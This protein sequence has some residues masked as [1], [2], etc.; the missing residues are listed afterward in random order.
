MANA[1]P[2][3]LYI[4]KKNSAKGGGRLPCPLPKIGHWILLLQGRPGYKSKLTA[5]TSTTEYNTEKILMKRAATA[6]GCAHLL[7]YMQHNTIPGDIW[8]YDMSICRIYNYSY[9]KGLV[10]N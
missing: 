1:L 6:Y 5:V 10:I 9:R 2:M 3:H 7:S 8:F 4:K